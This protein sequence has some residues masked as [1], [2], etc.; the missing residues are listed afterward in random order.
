MGIKLVMLSGLLSNYFANSLVSVFTASHCRQCNRFEKVYKTIE[1]S[2]PLI[3]FNVTY[4]N[5]TTSLYSKSM[6]IT[7]IP[8]LVFEDGEKLTG[9]PKNYDRIKEKCETISKTN[10]KLT[11]IPKNYD[12]IKS[13]KNKICYDHMYSAILCRDIYDDKILHS[14]EKYIDCI[15][16]SVQCMFKVKNDILFIAGRGS[17]EKN[18]WLHNFRF[19]MEEYPFKSN[20]KFHAGFLVQY[21][22]IRDNFIS[23]LDYMITKHE[24]K[25]IIFSGHSAASGWVSLAAFDLYKRIKKDYNLN[26]EVITFGSPRLA[27]EYFGDDFDSN[28]ECTRYINDRDLVTKVPFKFLGY[29]HL[30]KPI[31]IRNNGKMVKRDANGFQTLV[32]ILTGFP[33]ADVGLRDHYMDSY[34]KN[35]KECNNS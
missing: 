9:V 6:N 19:H 22:S 23:L 16:T 32:F 11:G 3:D 20:K 35:L 28:I 25:K 4:I 10:E 24:I 5:E 33:R 2:N 27:N 1:E 7:H 12:R 15:E 21:M 31:W 26:V 29:K 30:G 14:S 18:D 13:K 8:V 34:I 17:D